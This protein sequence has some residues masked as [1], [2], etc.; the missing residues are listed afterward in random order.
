MESF[1]S[2]KR[3]NPGCFHGGITISLSGSKQRVGLRASPR[4]STLSETSHDSHSAS[5]GLSF[6]SLV[7]RRTGPR[8]A[9]S[10]RRDLHRR[11]RSNRGRSHGYST[12]PEPS[13][14]HPGALALCFPFA[15]VRSTAHRQSRRLAR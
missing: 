14:A 13:A 3:Q 10:S 4:W 11:S 6:G 2:P 15:S 7:G 1:E 9:A 12:A 5:T 8:R